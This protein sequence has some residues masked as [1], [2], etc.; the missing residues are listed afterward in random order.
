MPNRVEKIGDSTLYLGDCLEI[1]PTLERDAGDLNSEVA[2]R[3]AQRIR[4]RAE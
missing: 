1:L 2:E 4:N 3:I